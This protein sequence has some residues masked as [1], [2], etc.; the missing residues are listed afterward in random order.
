ME[1]F[2]M[3]IPTLDYPVAADTRRKADWT[4]PKEKP[5]WK[6]QMLCCYRQVKGNPPKGHR[7][8][9]T[10]HPFTSIK[11]KAQL[12]AYLAGRPT[13][14]VQ[15]PL[16]GKGITGKNEDWIA[17]IDYAL[18]LVAMHASAWKCT[19]GAFFVVSIIPC[20][21]A[22]FKCYSIMALLYEL[23]GGKVKYE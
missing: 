7:L 14:P 13:S 5:H 19:K 17:A 9:W 1:T 3:Q 22:L 11:T 10:R 12:P 4:W 6:E 20:L 8:N 15:A 16:P 21:F 2:P 18:S 23:L